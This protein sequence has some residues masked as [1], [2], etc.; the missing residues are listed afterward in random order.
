MYA[1]FG[2]ETISHA[3]QIRMKE[4]VD[5]L[6]QFGTSHANDFPIGAVWLEEEILKGD[7]DEGKI[8]EETVATAINVL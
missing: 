4:G 8:A 1:Y 6:R 3:V 2:D 7:D 5:E